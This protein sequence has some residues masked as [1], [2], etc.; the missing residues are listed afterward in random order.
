MTSIDLTPWRGESCHHVKHTQGQRVI[1][2]LIYVTF[3]SRDDWWTERM[4]IYVIV[5]M[6]FLL[7]YSMIT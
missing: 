7:L 6:F 5:V 4:F 1:Q 3:E 2:F